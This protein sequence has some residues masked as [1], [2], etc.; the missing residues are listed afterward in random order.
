MFELMSKCRETQW[1]IT[2]HMLINYERAREMLQVGNFIIHPLGALHC[3]AFCSHLGRPCLSR[4]MSTYHTC[5][6]YAST[7][8][9]VTPAFF[10]RPVLAPPQSLPSSRRNPAVSRVINY[11]SGSFLING[12]QLSFT[13]YENVRIREELQ[14]LAIKVDNSTIS[15]C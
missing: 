13:L 15:T 3:A 4:S 6:R 2:S 1:G 10:Q 9:P 5:R 7:R 12:Y 11:S 8:S 14:R